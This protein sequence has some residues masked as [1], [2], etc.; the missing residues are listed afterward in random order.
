MRVYA[1]ANQEIHFLKDPGV[2]EYPGATFQQACRILTLIAKYQGSQ[3]DVER[4]ERNCAFR[5]MGF[6]AR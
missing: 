5:E 1:R 4:P 6:Y 2:N 3:V